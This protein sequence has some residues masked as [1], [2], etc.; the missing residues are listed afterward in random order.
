MITL[1]TVLNATLFIRLF[2]YGGIKYLKEGMDSVEND[3]D[4]PPLGVTLLLLATII[5]ACI[6]LLV[7]FI[8][9]ITYLP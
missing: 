5:L 1:F 8:L 7:A 9:C 3:Y 6:D 2:L 4:W